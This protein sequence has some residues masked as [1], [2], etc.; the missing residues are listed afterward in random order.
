MSTSDISTAITDYKNAIQK[1]KT[2]CIDFINSIE[3]IPI[4][5]VGSK[6]SNCFTVSFSTIAENN[7]ILSPF[8][9]DTKKQKEALITIVNSSKNIEFI[10]TF[11]EI[12]EKGKRTVRVGSSSYQQVFAP[13]VVSALKKFIKEESAL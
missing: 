5:R 9:Y 8:Y 13:S 12:A 3:E 7:S 10:K 2:L 4:E 1:F 11:E 6:N